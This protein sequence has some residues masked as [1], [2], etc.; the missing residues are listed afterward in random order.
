E[1]TGTEDPD[2]AAIKGRPIWARIL[3]NAVR[4][5]QRILPEQD[6]KVGSLR[7]RLRTED[8]IEAQSRARRSRQPHNLDGRTFVRPMLNALAEQYIEKRSEE[9]RVGKE[10]R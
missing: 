1:A 2:V 3:S 7:L 6:L 4:A 9:R 8:M 10:C 5:R